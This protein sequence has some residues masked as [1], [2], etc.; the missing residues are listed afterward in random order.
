MY[1]KKIIKLQLN[2]FKL[3]ST[4]YFYLPFFKNVII[5]KNITLIS[6]NFVKYII[7]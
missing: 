3:L 6:Y 1:V 4:R 5:T 2:F 7:F